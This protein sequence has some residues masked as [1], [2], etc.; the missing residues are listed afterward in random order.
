MSLGVF[1]FLE[2]RW[3]R[4]PGKWVVG[5]QVLGTDLKPCGFGRG[6]IRNVLLF[7]DGLFSYMVGIFIVALTEKWQR[8]G[9]LAA[10]T[11]VVQA[12]RFGTVEPEAVDRQFVK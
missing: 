4:T 2:G 10:R 9:D 3:G 6:L 1:S 11:V 12:P 7:A 8:V 5:I